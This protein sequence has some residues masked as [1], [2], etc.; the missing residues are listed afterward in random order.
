MIV[1]LFL[2]FFRIIIF[3]LFFPGSEGGVS[4]SVSADDGSDARC[5]GCRCPSPG[6]TG[7]VQLTSAYGELVVVQKK[8]DRER[9]IAVRDQVL[10]KSPPPSPAAGPP[11]VLSPCPGEPFPKKICRAM[12]PAHGGQKSQPWHEVIGHLREA[13]PPRPFFFRLPSEGR[14]SRVMVPHCSL[15]DRLV[16]LGWACR[17]HL[18]APFS[19]P[20]KSQRV[21]E[22]LSTISPPSL[23]L[24]LVLSLSACN[25]KG[26]RTE[27]ARSENGRLFAVVRLSIV[28]SRNVSEQYRVSIIPRPRAPPGPRQR[29][30]ISHTPPFLPFP[31]SRPLPSPGRR[32]P[33]VSAVRSGEAGIG[34]SCYHGTSRHAGRQLT[35]T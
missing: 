35:Q 31:T 8:I 33:P 1:L 22:S 17:C 19:T 6:N 9:R 24:A 30:K 25:P 23:S 18:T 26:S 11:K 5:A 15:R 32:V 4:L 2:F 13:I 3:L 16:E 28:S 12:E 20:C 29:I 10:R 21:G 14:M 7:L 34:C 27:E